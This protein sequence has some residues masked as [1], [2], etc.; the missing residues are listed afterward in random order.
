MEEDELTEEWQQSDSDDVGDDADEMDFPNMEL[1]LTPA[2]TRAAWPLQDSITF[3]GDYFNCYIDLKH[4]NIWAGSYSRV[5]FSGTC[6]TGSY[7]QTTGWDGVSLLNGPK[8]HFDS[9]N[10]EVEEPGHPEET[11]L[12][13]FRPWSVLVGTTVRWCSTASSAC[14][15]QAFSG[16]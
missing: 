10:C 11:W 2:P 7:V 15:T 5:L 16:I 6:G 14:V 4:G 3:V 12:Q 8:C 1:A 13:S 9:G